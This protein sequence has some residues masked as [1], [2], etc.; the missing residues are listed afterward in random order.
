VTP[1]QGVAPIRSN[2]IIREQNVHHNHVLAITI[3]VD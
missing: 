1:Y 3:D 2:Q